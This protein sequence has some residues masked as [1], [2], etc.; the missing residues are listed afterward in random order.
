[1]ERDAEAATV[2]F[3]EGDFAT[4]YAQR[5]PQLCWN[6]HGSGLAGVRG[7]APETFPAISALALSDSSRLS[8]VAAKVILR[9]FG[10]WE[11]LAARFEE[12]RYEVAKAQGSA[13]G[14]LPL[15]GW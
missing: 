14:M 10:L 5:Y 11:P 8:V 12:L 4:L 3:P 13:L 1:V 9:H 15:S 7:I 6:T 2:F